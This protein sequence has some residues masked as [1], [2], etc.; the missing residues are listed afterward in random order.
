MTKEEPETRQGV[1][2]TIHLLDGDSGM[3]AIFKDIGGNG[4]V[5]ESDI[6]DTGS[7]EED[8]SLNPRLYSQ[9]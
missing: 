7:E 8:V 1:P 4:V 2:T 9:G 5:T 3:W 6:Q